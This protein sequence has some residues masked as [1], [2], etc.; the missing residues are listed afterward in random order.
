ML[1][2]SV[3]K[4]LII[5]LRIVSR[6][7]RFQFLLGMVMQHAHRQTNRVGTVLR[8][9]CMQQS[10]LGPKHQ[11]AVKQVSLVIEREVDVVKVN[12]TSDGQ[13]LAALPR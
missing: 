11:V 2:T 6:Y 10:A 7:Q 4:S 13:P 9:E 12:A 8:E 3:A 5:V 1:S